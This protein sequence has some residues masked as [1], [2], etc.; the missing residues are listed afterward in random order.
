M[1]IASFNVENLTDAP[2]SKVL[3]S[4]RLGSLLPQ[5]QR[6][7]ADIIC[8]QEVN[9]TK[10]S[11]HVRELS[12][13]RNLMNGTSYENF[14]VAHT[15]LLNSEYPA[16]KH[17]LVVLSRWPYANIKQYQNE[18]VVAPLITSTT[19]KPG[20]TEPQSLVWDRP[21]LHVQVALPLEQKFRTNLLH[22]INLHL[23]APLAAPIPGQKIGPFAWR[24]VS[25]WAEG[26]LHAAIKRSGQALEARLLIDRIFDQDAHALI[27]LA[28]DF[29]AEER[30][31][32]LRLVTGNPEDTGNGQLSSRALVLLEHSVPELQRFTIIHRGRKQMLDHL[33][34]SRSLFGAYRRIEIH[35]EMLDDELVAFT[36]INATTESYHAPIV[37]DFDL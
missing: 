15:H 32:P 28:G 17:N 24:T 16:D 14:H 10:T 6:M 36:L 23:K 11:A 18:L 9:A 34:V 31:V 25:G 3:L 8:L 2:D 7:D 21:L 37:A 13:L 4:E 35:N 26:Y 12:V 30:E 20:Q 27:L 1:R 22:I 29:N 19:S 33:L 5:L